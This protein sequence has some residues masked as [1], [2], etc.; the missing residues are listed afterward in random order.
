HADR[1]DNVRFLVGLARAF[2]GAIIFSLP[3]MMTM[4]MWWLGFYMGRLQLALLMVLMLPMLVG[5]DR[6]S[7][8]EHTSTWGQDVLDALVAY[9]VAFVAAGVLLYLFGVISLTLPLRE[10]VGKVALQAVPASFGAVLAASQLGGADPAEQRRRQRAGYPGEVFFMLAGALFLAF[11]LAPTEE[12]VLI[13]YQMTPW[14]ALA[15]A[16]VSLA[17]MHAF[18]YAVDFRGTPAVPEGVRQA[19][20][21]LRFTVVGYAV[22]LLVSAYVLWSFGRLQDEAPIVMVMHTVVL[23][24]PATLGAAAARLLL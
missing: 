12:M 15:L 7:G 21:F 2:A 1:S 5:L 11:N 4:E 3:L 23:G 8:F 22:A 9:A 18:V 17:V 24:F 6:Y 20:I 13:S 16:A 19:S 14:H 10:V